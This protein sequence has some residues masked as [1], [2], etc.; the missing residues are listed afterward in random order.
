MQALSLSLSLSW[1]ISPLR[2]RSACN[3]GCHHCCV[4]VLGA[5][6]LLLVLPWIPTPYYA[7]PHSQTEKQLSYSI[8]L[9]IDVQLAGKCA[10]AEW[11]FSLLRLLPFAQPSANSLFAVRKLLGQFV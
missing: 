3:L 4:S 9:E 8:M 2:A 5:V 11:K 7:E 10:P 6:L 1:Y